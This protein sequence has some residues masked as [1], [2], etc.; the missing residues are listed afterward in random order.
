M[1]RITKAA[2]AAAV[3]SLGV[4]V[5]HAANADHKVLLCHATNSAENPYEL[6]S[7]DWHGAQ[8]H[9]AAGHGDSEHTDFLLPEGRTDCINQPGE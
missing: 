9:L 4:S 7:I 8:G 1:R 5:A 2:L 6:I 3:C